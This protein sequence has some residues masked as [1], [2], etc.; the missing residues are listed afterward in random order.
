MGKFETPGRR[1]R[2][3]LVQPQKK[4]LRHLW[5]KRF[6]TAAGVARFIGVS[7]ETVRAWSSRK[8]GLE[9]IIPH[10]KLGKNLIRYDRESIIDFMKAR[11]YNPKAE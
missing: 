2:E 1:A 9:P 4:H 8:N 7:E 10:I 5:Q 6:L 3:Q 11:E